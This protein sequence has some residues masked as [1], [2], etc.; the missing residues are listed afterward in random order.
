MFIPLHDLK[1]S[2]QGL[3]S[4]TLTFVGL[5]LGIGTDLAGEL[6][7]GLIIDLLEHAL[8]LLNTVL[9]LPSESGPGYSEPFSKRLHLL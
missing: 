4:K 9:G 7:D 3:S 2:R 1:D 5:L 8:E 6:P